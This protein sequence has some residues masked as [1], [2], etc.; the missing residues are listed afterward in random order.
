MEE[1]Y[2]KLNKKIDELIKKNRT[3][4]SHSTTTRSKNSTIGR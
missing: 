2:N 1:T 3:K 4:P